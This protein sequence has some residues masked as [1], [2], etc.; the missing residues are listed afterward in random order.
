MWVPSSLAWLMSYMY[1]ISN[2]CISHL[3]YLVIHSSQLLEHITSF[4]TLGSYWSHDSYNVHQKLNNSPNTDH[5]TI[6]F[7]RVAIRDKAITASCLLH[8]WLS[9]FLHR[10]PEDLEEPCWYFK[11]LAILLFLLSILLKELIAWFL[12]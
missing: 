5:R 7:P 9:S 3:H 1:I 8:I 4:T 11:K 10:N 6:T 12:N 2:K